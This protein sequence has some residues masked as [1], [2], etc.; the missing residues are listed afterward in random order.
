LRAARF[1]FLRSS[2]LVMLLVFAMYLANL[3]I[4]AIFGTRGALTGQTSLPASLRRAVEI[5]L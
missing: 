3:S 1:T 4:A 5:V 2:L